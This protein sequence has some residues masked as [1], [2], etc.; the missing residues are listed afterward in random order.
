MPSTQPA[1]KLLS[2]QLGISHKK[3]K[4]L[5]DR[6]LVGVGG[7]PLRLARAK[8]PLDAHFSLLTPKR[9]GILYQ[10]DHLLALNKSAHTESYAL[11]RQHP[12]YQLLHR[13]DQGTSG[14]LL[15]ATEP[16]YSQALQAFRQRQVYKEYLAVV[17]GVIK[18]PQTLKMP[19]RVQKSHP[20][21]NKGFVKTDIDPKGQE[22]ITHLS[23]LTTYKNHTLL[24]VV[25]KTGVTHQIRAH[26]SAIQ[27]PI[28]G[29]QLYGAH[30]HPYLLL[31]AHKIALL[32]YTLS[33]PIP[34]HF[35][36]FDELLEP[37]LQ[38]F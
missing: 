33:A 17:Q 36:E 22:A 11:Q 18:E 10:D 6:G 3:A 35:K 23:P 27:H 34:P 12:P 26:L 31:H 25:I 13:L 20:H 24:K 38:P 9:A 2:L 32:G 5:I 14:V 28:I 15:L 30:P 16:L 19:L 37:D 21:F 29:D 1:Y 7:K 8:L 4:M